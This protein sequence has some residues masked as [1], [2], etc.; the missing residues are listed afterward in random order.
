MV[1]ETVGNLLTFSVSVAFV[2]TRETLAAGFAGLVISYTL[3]VTQGLSWFVRMATELETNVVSVERIREY[4]E[5]TIEWF[6]YSTL[7]II[8]KKVTWSDMNSP[9]APWDVPTK[10]PPPQ[11]PQ[12]EIEFV[13]YSTR[14]R[15]DLDFVLRSLSF[16]ISPGEKIGIVGRTGSGKSSLV[17]ALFR[18][19]EGREGEI[20]VDGRNIAE[21]GLHDLRGRIT[22]IPQASRSFHCSCFYLLDPVLFSGT[23]RFNLD[24]F[25][26]HSEDEVWEALTLANLRP[27]V[28]EASCD[29]LK[30][31]IAEGGNNL[32]VGQRQLVCLARALL[33]QSRILVLDEATAAVDPQTDQLIQRTVRKEFASSTVL[34]IAHR[35]DTIIDYDRIMVLDAGRLIEM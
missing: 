2:A 20:R 13:N 4:S 28:E 19:I 8:F 12:G 15:D 7:N 5:L 23:L 30:M 31:T 34:T 29:G 32:S 1:L 22:L 11:W 9:S 10:Q 25:N 16:T 27:F 33:R 26:T 14:Y 6:T 3:N 21:I 17:L 18:I 24:P 35:L